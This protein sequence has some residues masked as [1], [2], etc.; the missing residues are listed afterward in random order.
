MDGSR[1]FLKGLS[2]LT[3]SFNYEIKTTA[4]NKYIELHKYYLVGNKN[5]SVENTDLMLARE[6][7]KEPTEC[8]VRS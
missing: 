8:K 2:Q 7:V 4:L 1:F 5:T 6:S 3:Y